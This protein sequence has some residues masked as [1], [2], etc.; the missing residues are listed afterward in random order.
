[1][2]QVEEAMF[3]WT[4]IQAISMLKIKQVEMEM[5]ERKGGKGGGQT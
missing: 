3:R 5:F 1:M 4:Q 2:G